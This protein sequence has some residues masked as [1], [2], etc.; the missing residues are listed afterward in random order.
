MDNLIA[1]TAT[2]LQQREV[3][4]ASG[5]LRELEQTL[6][7]SLRGNASDQQFEQAVKELLSRAGAGNIQLPIAANTTNTTDN[8]SV[9][10]MGPDEWLFRSEPAATTA[11]SSALA[12]EVCAGAFS[13]MHAAAVDVSDYYTLFELQSPN[14]LALL[15]RS[16]PLDLEKAFAEAGHCAQTRIGN[17]A[18]LLD[19]DDVSTWRIQ[20]RWSYAQY[21]WQLLERSALSL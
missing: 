1:E 14:A 21:L 5:Q 18:V 11:L 17:A 8:C 13:E 10:W 12:E 16:C 9:F 6:K 15:S 7:I 20:V 3:S 2:P 19:S 4:L